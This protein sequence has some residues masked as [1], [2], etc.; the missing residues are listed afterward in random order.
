MYIEPDEY[1]TYN[2]TLTLSSGNTLTESVAGDSGAQFF[3]WTGSGVTSLTIAS[4]DP[5]AAGDFFSSAAPAVPE[6]SAIVLLATIL[7]ALW[8]G[9]RRK[10]HA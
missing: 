5:F 7:A 3:G 6:P 9:L 2:I 4:T 1:S 10:A 8:V